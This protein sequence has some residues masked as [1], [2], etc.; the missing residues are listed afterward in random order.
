MG[1]AS[2]PLSERLPVWRCVTQPGMF[3]EQAHLLSSACAHQGVTVSTG[4]KLALP[5]F[6][7]KGGLT[8]TPKSTW[9]P[10]KHRAVPGMCGTE[11]N[12][13]TADIF[14]SFL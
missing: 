4:N 6:G 5:L 14:V 1:G 8:P 11:P 13:E 10:L 7:I 2:R 12:L 9:K 3:T